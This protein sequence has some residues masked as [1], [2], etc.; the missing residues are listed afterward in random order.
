MSYPKCDVCN[1]DSKDNIVASSACGPISFCYCKQC[2]SSGAEPYG[3]LVAYLS[4][5]VNKGED[6]EPEKSLI[7]PGYQQVIDISLE[8]AKKT[9][10]EF[11][12]D[13]D[14]IL[15]K[16]REYWKNLEEKDNA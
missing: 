2:G 10:E 11:Y 1:F 14:N 12:K 4:G 3:A 8:L 9:R 16:E 5:V 6:L 13:V 7:R 15:E